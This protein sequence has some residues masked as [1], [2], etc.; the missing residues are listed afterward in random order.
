MRRNQEK[1]LNIFI[2]L[3]SAS[4]LLVAIYYAYINI[5]LYRTKNKDTD[6]LNKICRGVFSNCNYVVPRKSDES[7]YC[8]NFKALVAID[9]DESIV[10]QEEGL[11]KTIHIFKNYQL[12][13]N[14]VKKKCNL[15]GINAYG[16]FAFNQGD[17]RDPRQL[18]AMVF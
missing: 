11:R 5:S 12:M 14:D 8:S 7:E 2:K 13:Y 16:I 9:N 4:A 6:E 10:C 18:R 17:P 1:H 15:D 3:F